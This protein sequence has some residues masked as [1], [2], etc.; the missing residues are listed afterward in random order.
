MPGSLDP[1]FRDFLLQCIIDRDLNPAPPRVLKGTCHGAGCTDPLPKYRC[2]DCFAAEDLCI[3][4]LLEQHIHNPLH[5]IEMWTGRDFSPVDLKS[6]GMRIQLGHRA[7]DICPN[8]L[9]DHTFKIID[10]R[11]IQGVCLAYCGCPNASSYG[12][13]LRAA[14][15]FPDKAD[16]PTVAV[17]YQ[18]VDMFTALNPPLALR[19]RAQA[20]R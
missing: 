10:E 7:N 1:V 9:V 18:L 2:L 20:R 12:A 5:K 13:Q 3:S 19:L 14:R 8:R 6:V 16:F 11:G 15:L 4:C 17:V